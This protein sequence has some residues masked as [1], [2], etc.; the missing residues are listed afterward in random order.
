M[1]MLMHN[2]QLGQEIAPE[3]RGGASRSPFPRRN[4]LRVHL[5]R[6]VGTADSAEDASAGLGAQSRVPLGLQSRA[7]DRPVLPVPAERARF[8]VHSSGIRRGYDR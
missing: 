2:A 4:R 8:Q 6:A 7:P 1:H 5:D 3:G